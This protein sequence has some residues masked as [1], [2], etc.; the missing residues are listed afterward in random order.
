MMGLDC[1]KGEAGGEDDVR[2]YL[3]YIN[4]L[5]IGLYIRHDMIIE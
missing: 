2:R 3:E 4:M 5:T 1:W